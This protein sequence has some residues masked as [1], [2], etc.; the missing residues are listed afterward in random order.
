MME[1]HN[2]IIINAINGNVKVSSI[3]LKVKIRAAKGRR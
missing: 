3:K 2:C 1:I